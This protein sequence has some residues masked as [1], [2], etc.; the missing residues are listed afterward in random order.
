MV[1]G[2]Q[3]V[4]NK[5]IRSEWRNKEGDWISCILGTPLWL[6]GMDRRDV[7]E[8]GEERVDAR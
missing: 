3:Y 4:F 1:P 6:Q 8:D 5:G 7:R 2:I